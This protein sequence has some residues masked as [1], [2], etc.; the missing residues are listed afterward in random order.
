MMQCF[1]TVKHNSFY[2][3][4]DDVNI[5]KNHIYSWFFEKYVTIGFGL[6]IYF[7]I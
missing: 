6:M 3:T 7:T 4:D 1:M 5:V 2:F